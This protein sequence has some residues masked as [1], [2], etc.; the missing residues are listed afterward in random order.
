[1]S[2]LHK[3]SLKEYYELIGA[4][5]KLT[6]RNVKTVLTHDTTPT[7]P[8]PPPKARPVQKSNSRPK[9]APAPK[10]HRKIE[11]EDVIAPSDSEEQF[12]LK[13]LEGCVFGDVCRHRRIWVHEDTKWTLG[14][15]LS[16]ESAATDQLY[17]RLY[18]V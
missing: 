3:M 10:K 4:G 1:M 11:V 13:F 9:Q 2:D 15:I 6:R 16:L 5:K 17:P 8:P 7:P 18:E 14:R 12:K